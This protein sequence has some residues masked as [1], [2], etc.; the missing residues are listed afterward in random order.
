MGVGSNWPWCSSRS[1]P[2]SVLRVRA[3]CGGHLFT[4]KL[5]IVVHDLAHQL[6]DHLLADEAILLARQFCDRLRDRIDHFI[7]FIGI[8]FV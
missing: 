5:G 2:P 1:E 8:N 3:D 6:L 4:A 7:R